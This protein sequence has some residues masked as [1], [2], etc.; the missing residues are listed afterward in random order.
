[1]A[2]RTGRCCTLHG[3]NSAL[4]ESS[5]YG[6]LAR[7]E[8]GTLHLRSAE[9]KDRPTW[10]H[11]LRSSTHRNHSGR[12]ILLILCHDYI[13][14]RNEIWRA[15]DYR[16]GRISDSRD[17]GS[18]LVCFART[19]SVSLPIRHCAQVLLNSWEFWLKKFFCLIDLYP[20][21]QPFSLHFGVKSKAPIIANLDIQK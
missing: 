6:S 3:D 16:R 13:S 17:I 8:H 10:P 19:A 4:W 9:R 11:R 12:I 7:S 5:L 18:R 15:C 21:P 1:M 20:S 14:G 2:Y